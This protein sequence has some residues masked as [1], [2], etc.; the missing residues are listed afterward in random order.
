M[1]RI[2]LVLQQSLSPLTKD[3]PKTIKSEREWLDKLKWRE[4]GLVES[5]LRTIRKKWS[6]CVMENMKL[7]GMEEHVT[8]D[9]QMWGQGQSLPIQPHPR[10]ENVDVK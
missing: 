8:Q 1:S 7:F 2:S 3:K 9:R 6:D 5:L 4:T 10:W